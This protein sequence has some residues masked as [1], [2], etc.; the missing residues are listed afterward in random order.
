MAAPDYAG[1][2]LRNGALRSRDSP[3]G[4]RQRVAPPLYTPSGGGASVV[5]IRL[6]F[7]EPETVDDTLARRGESIP[8][9][10]GRSTH[11]R[12]V[13]LRRFL[14]RNVDRLPRD[15]RASFCKLLKTRWDSA[16]FELIVARTLQLLG[17]SLSFERPNAEGRRPDFI[18]QFEELSVVV[19]AIAPEF[20]Q[21]MTLQE[22]KHAQLLDIIESRVPEGW[23]VLLGAL[24]DF[25]F[26]ESKTD[27]KKA[28][29]AAS[30]QP[31]PRNAQDCRPFR[32]DL[33]QGTL[34]FTLVP[35]RFGSR[36]IG[37]GP[38]YVGWSD[39]KE[40]IRHALDKKRSQVRAQSQPVLLAI[41]ASGISA[42]FDDFDDVL[43]G[44]HVTE[45]GPDLQT[46]ATRFDA[47]GSF[48]RGSGPPTYSGVLAFTELTPFGCQGPV[49]YVH[50][51]S[52]AT[53]PKELGVLARRSLDADGIKI[54]PSTEP[55]LL[56]DLGWAKL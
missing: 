33:P 40:R 11:P 43:F 56:D 17:A 42:G 51:R 2:F 20:D 4:K 38:V 49:L 44:H 34:K 54:S 29:D 39:A 41:L 35:G 19:E 5:A 22:E 18:A 25:G 7:P 1:N 6:C 55:H 12:A 15:A 31:P 13:E 47:S 30:N 24:P 10:L 48:A 16:L 23:T 36:A 28:L 8:H 3:R 14:N 32:F 9:C 52:T 46:R 37:G 53:L 50:P 26:S 45:L 21:Q 27:L